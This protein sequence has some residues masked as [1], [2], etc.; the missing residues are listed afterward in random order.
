MAV[1][2][3]YKHTYVYVTAAVYDVILW[4]EIIFTCIEL[5]ISRY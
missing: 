1:D 3:L 4:P 2:I 5:A